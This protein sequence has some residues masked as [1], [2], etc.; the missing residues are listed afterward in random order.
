MT[1][2]NV[3]KSGKVTC[4]KE[5]NCKCSI[6]TFSDSYIFD[7]D[8]V[9]NTFRTKPSQEDKGNYHNQSCLEILGR[10][11][12]SSLIARVLGAQTNDS[13]FC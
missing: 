1:P 5:E 11:K 8:A 7:F 9:F 12:L 2:D 3:K 13:M 6:E 10:E 4:I